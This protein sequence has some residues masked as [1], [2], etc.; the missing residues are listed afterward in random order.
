MGGRGTAKAGKP[1]IAG[2]GYRICLKNKFPECCPLEDV[3]NDGLEDACP[4]FAKDILYEFEDVVKWKD[5]E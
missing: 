1:R 5:D 2:G 3:G 4:E